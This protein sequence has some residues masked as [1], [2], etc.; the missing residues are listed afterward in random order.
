[1]AV[2]A[3]A[4]GERHVLRED[5]GDLVAA[6][7]PAEDSGEQLNQLVLRDANL[8]RHLPIR[9]QVSESR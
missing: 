3:I 4:L 7:V 5:R 6:A 9:G 2:G 8:R 1:M